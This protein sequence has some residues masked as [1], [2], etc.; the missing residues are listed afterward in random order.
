[1][2]D[3]T[4]SDKSHQFRAE[5]RCEG[6]VKSKQYFDSLVQAK[7]WL[8]VETDFARKLCEALVLDQHDGDR[9]VY[10]LR[11]KGKSHKK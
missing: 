7:V 3:S 2:R 6:R 8:V 9:R 11:A 4:E 1:M 10:V 5:I